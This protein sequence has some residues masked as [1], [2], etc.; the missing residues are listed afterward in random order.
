V[1]CLWTCSSKGQSRDSRPSGVDA[2]ILTFVSYHV[3]TPG[4]LCNQQSQGVSLKSCSVH[5]MEIRKVVEGVF[6]F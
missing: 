1:P 3:L 2:S 6:L 4:V 5:V